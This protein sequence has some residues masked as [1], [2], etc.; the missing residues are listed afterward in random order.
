MYLYIDN[1]YFYTSG[2]G[3]GGSPTGPPPVPTSPA[4]DV[5][6]IYSDSYSN[7]AGTNLN[8]NWGQAT[9]VSEI[10]FNGNKILK[11]GGLN[12]QGTQLGSNQNVTSMNFLHVDYWSA[13][14]SNLNIFIISPGPVETAY[15]LNVPTGGWQSIDIPLSAFQPVNL[16]NVFQFKFDGNGDIFIDNLYFK[17]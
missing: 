5:I 10:N 12:Y 16:S 11:Y 1:V 8:P 4:S 2:G 6:S 3:Q 7:V 14:S 15:A 13:N 17:K 9:T